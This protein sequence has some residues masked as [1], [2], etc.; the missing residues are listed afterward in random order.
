MKSLRDFFLRPA[1]ALVV[2]VAATVLAA[3][4]VGALGVGEEGQVALGRGEDATDMLQLGAAAD[5][6]GSIV[7]E[8]QKGSWH[9]MSCA[10][11]GRELEE[12]E[13]A[14]AAVVIMNSSELPRRDRRGCST[15]SS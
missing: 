3:Q 12:D 10:A 14:V 6:C 15:G 8:D 4:V 5:G 1:T 13:A 7:E 9:V 11:G 2:L